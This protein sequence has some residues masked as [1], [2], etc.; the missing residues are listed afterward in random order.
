MQS[1]SSV[2]NFVALALGFSIGV[3]LSAAAPSLSLADARAAPD[4]TC[5]E[6]DGVYLILLVP[7]TG[8]AILATRSFPGS[9]QIGTID[10][11][12][13]RFDLP[14]VSAR[15]L[16]LA[17]TYSATSPVWGMLDRTLDIG[18]ESGCFSF[19]DRSFSSVDDLKTYL[20]WVVQ[21]IL[22]RLK[23]RGEAGPFALTLG[24]RS[25][26]LDV[27]PHGHQA[28][29]VSAYEAGLAGVRLP[30]SD[31]I[32]YFQPIILNAAAERLAVKVLAKDGPFFGEGTAEEID[33]LLVGPEAVGRTS[34]DPPLEIRCAAI[35]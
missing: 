21:D 11:D 16:P 30:D 26:T 32:Y 23:A 24:D 34:T 13:I 2:R 4:L 9:Q 17:R 3:P 5:P 22:F 19:G 18:S 27:T 28:I 33:F 29:R 25:I 1:S 35:E 31:I 7:E 20:H 15:E 10:G 6:A 8:L 14:G 12:H